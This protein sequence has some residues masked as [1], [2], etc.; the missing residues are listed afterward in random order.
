ML[1]ISPCL[2][3]NI[4]SAYCKKCKQIPS[5]GHYLYRAE[6]RDTVLAAGLFEVGADYAGPIYYEGPEDASL[7]DGI[8]RAGF[9]YAAEQ[10]LEKGMI[11]EEFRVRHR[12]KFRQLNYP[13]Q[14]FFNIVNF[15]QK[16]KNCGRS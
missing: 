15:F 11:P 16:Y 9:N 3:R 8:L 13:I 7:F 5:P 1:A 10:G 12:E 14:A 2:D 4:V 6:D